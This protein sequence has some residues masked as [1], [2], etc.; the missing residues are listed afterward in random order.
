[1]PGILISI[2]QLLSKLFD[3]KHIHYQNIVLKKSSHICLA[4]HQ[5]DFSHEEIKHLHTNSQAH[6]HLLHE[7]FCPK[8]M[9]RRCFCNSL[10]YFA[11]GTEVSSPNNLCRRRKC[12]EM[13]QD[14]LL[15]LGDSQDSFITHAAVNSSAE[16]QPPL[17]SKLTPPQL[18]PITN[19]RI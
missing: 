5:G 16:I 15:Q 9:W 3:K 6:T 14:A 19:W 7:E 2:F 17:G 11:S 8:Q 10:E 12:Q 18:I 4:L 1:M 13:Q